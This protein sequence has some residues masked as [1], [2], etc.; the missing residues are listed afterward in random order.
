MLQVRRRTLYAAVIATSHPAPP[1]RV[2][3]VNSRNRRIGTAAKDSVHSAE[4]PLH[5]AFSCYVCDGRGKTLITKR[6]ATKVTFPGVWTNAVCGHPAPGERTISA[7]RRR[8]QVELGLN[9]GAIEC[10]LPDFRYRA[11]MNGMVEN[12]ICPV[13]T[14]LVEGAPTPTPLPSE[15]DAFRW[16]TWGQF[17]RLLRCSAASTFSPWCHRQ[18]AEL[19]TSGWTPIW[20]NAE[21]CDG[22]PQG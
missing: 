1:D 4:T 13:F 21:Q 19:E 3:L 6:S 7:V 10:V 12:E 14:A 22:I 16:L 18:V 8:L 2:V 5:R 11:A 15:V 17:A 20:G 9:A